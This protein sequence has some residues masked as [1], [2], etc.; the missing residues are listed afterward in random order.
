VAGQVWQ[1]H[2][3][4][5]RFRGTVTMPALFRFACVATLLFSSTV[6]Q[7]SAQ[8]P[9][10][11]EV[12][13]LKKNTT[14]PGGSR[15]ETLPDG[16]FRMINMPLIVIVTLISPFVVDRDHVVGIP[17][18]VWTEPYDVIA[19]PPAGATAD[20]QNDRLRSLLAERLKFVAHV[21]EREQDTYSLTF[22]RTDRARGP[23]LKPST[24]D[25]S[26]GGRGRLTPPGLAPGMEAFAQR[27]GVS[28]APG[29]AV[30]GSSTIER[31]ARTLIGLVGRMVVDHTGLEGDYSWSIQF[32]PPTRAGDAVPSDAPDIFTALREQLGLR[33]EPEKNK[34]PFLVIDHIERPTPN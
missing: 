7:V 19:K 16:T 31:M 34:V 6:G 21:E 18:W 14:G 4:C 5:A 17:D 1:T 28:M 13:S 24:L 23:K 12:A 8:T 32:A 26:P 25:C 30:S 10:S 22:A 2:I 27:C 15:L 3:M 29:W 20:G 11:F 9:P 33:L